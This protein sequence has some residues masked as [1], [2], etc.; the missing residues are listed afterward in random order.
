MFSTYLGAKARAKDLRRR[1][2]VSGLDYSLAKCQ[3]AL[4]R[5]AGYPH[6]HALAAG[7][8][9]APKPLDKD[10]FGARLITVLPLACEP[11]AEAWL[12]GDPTPGADPG[13]RYS[14]A[15]LECVHPWT[16][17]ICAMHR[18]TPLLRRGSGRGQRLRADIVLWPLLSSYCRLDPE[19]LATAFAGE[20]NVILRR[21]VSHPQFHREFERLCTAGIIRWAPKRG[22]FGTLTILPPPIDDV[23]DHRRMCDRHLAEYWA[24]V[25]AAHV[26]EE[27]AGPP[28]TGPNPAI[29]RWARE[30]GN[31]GALGA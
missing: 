11:A 19:T 8:R 26:R 15:W 1:F 18:D 22:D 16:G 27:R 4:A 17:S 9:A 5:A 31:E 10:R 7:L 14:D 28:P 24:E 21:N 30:V 3:S 29:Q 20:L 25:A 6:W 13:N 2:D 23:V 12:R